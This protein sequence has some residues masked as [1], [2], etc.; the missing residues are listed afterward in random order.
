MQHAHSVVANDSGLMHMAAALSKPV[1]AIYGAT[2]P[3]FAPPLTTQGKAFAIDLPCRPCGKN[4]CPL[5][6]LDCLHGVSVEEI[7]RAIQALTPSA[8]EKFEKST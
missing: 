6:T 2:P 7:F 1:M 5:N 3:H 4:Q 8:T